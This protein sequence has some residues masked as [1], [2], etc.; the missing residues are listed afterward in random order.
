MAFRVPVL[1]W[2]S[3]KRDFFCGIFFFTFGLFMWLTIPFSIPQI[4]LFTQ[5]GPRFF[6]TFFS[7]VM[8]L[9]GFILALQSFL[10][11]DSW[12]KEA[13]AKALELK[14]EIPVFVT[15]II[16]AVSCFLFSRFQ[17]LISMSIAVTVILLFFKTK[18]WY[19]YFILY[20]FIILFYFIFT[21][22]MFV[23]LN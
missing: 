8:T 3:M 9:L 18:K 23:P 21:R 4:D 22:F 19:H 14:R 20:V 1:F 15:F 11:K 17:Y 6:P 12:K 5:M 2:S 7:I 10:K 13:T 16:M